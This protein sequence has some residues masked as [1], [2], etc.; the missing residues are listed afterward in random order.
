MLPVVENMNWF[1]KLIFGLQITGIGM[2]TVFIVLCVLFILIAIMGKIFQSIEK[3]DAAVK[4]TG[5]QQTTITEVE[6][7][8]NVQDDLEIV[9]VLTAAIS[10]VTGKS[11]SRFNIRSFRKIK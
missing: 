2:G 4:T 8:S 9:A 1:E 10:A 7:V 11:T 3:D 6:S 5:T